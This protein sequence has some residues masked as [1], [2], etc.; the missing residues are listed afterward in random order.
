MV[1]DYNGQG[2]NDLDQSIFKTKS[3]TLYW[4]PVERKGRHV[5]FFKKN[6]TY[7]G[8]VITKT[9]LIAKILGNTGKKKKKIV[10]E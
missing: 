7:Q 2:R 3:V 4:K 1:V 9:L 8:F 10:E 6:T 5:I